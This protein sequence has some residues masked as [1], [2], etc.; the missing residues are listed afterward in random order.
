MIYNIGDR[1][2]NDQSETC[3]ILATKTTPLTSDYLNS[4]DGEILIRG[5]KKMA[6]TEI[7]VPDGFD[8]IVSKIKSFEGK[9]CILDNE[10]PFNPV[11][12]DDLIR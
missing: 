3:I 4:L 2:K 1:I 7:H 11:F 10:L 5:I 9:Y 8:Y 6:R 12:E